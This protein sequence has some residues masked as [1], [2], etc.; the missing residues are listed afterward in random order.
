MMT[1]YDTES[2]MNSKE[3]RGCHLCKVYFVST[4]RNAFYLTWSERYAHDAAFHTSLDAAKHHAEQKRVQGTVF[5]IDELPALAFPVDS[6]A[7]LVTEINTS[8]AFEGFLRR[9][10]RT[11]TVSHIASF[12]TP[13]RVNS[14]QRLFC[15]SDIPVAFFPLRRFRSS[16]RGKA[17]PLTWEQLE[18]EPE[19][20][21]DPKFAVAT[22]TRL[23]K[24]LVGPIKKPNAIRPNA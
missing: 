23:H 6:G 21:H 14:I 12:F 24:W 7:L 13:P 3:V 17:Y 8:T 11:R 19:D 20:A 9:T 4:G 18:L 2:P 15:E 1:A 10:P 22:A 5:S 16:S